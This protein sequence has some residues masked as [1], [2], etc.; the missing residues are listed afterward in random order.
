MTGFTEIISVNKVGINL[1]TTAVECSDG[2][3]KTGK[4]VFLSFLHIMKVQ[5]I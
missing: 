2:Q 3:S 5:H 4:L 1:R